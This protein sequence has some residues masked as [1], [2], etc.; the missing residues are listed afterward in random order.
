[1]IA[2]F[3]EATTKDPF[4]ALAWA[5]LAFCC[6]SMSE[7]D[8]DKNRADAI[9]ASEKAMQFRPQTGEALWAEAYVQDRL[10]RNYEKANFAYH[11]AKDRLPGEPEIRM[12]LAYLARRAGKWEDSLNYFQEAMVCY[13]WN[14]G[15]FKQW[16]E[17]NQAMH[18]F[19]VALE[20]Y[21]R[22]LKAAEYIDI[23]ALEISIY[24]AQ[25][26]FAKSGDLLRRL[27]LNPSEP[28]T[29]ESHFQQL[30]LRR[31]FAEAKKL[32]EQ[33]MAGSS[34]GSF[35]YTKY[36]IQHG[37]LEDALDGFP[38]DDYEQARDELKILR[39]KSPKDAEY[40]LFLS[41]AYLGLRRSDQAQAEAT[42]AVHLAGRS[43][44]AYVVLRMN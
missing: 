39:Q 11:Q 44:S 2:A 12:H 22:L 28:I 19:D 20:A 8:D 13:L 10:L 1:M 21:E 36:R 4:F 24:Q 26:D 14:S 6:V 41:Q 31:Q 35:Q 15:A 27:E 42:E 34:L 32:I 38:R 9:A 17:T 43:P 18:R 5:E 16:G 7:T 29:V 23:L 33:A 25:G 3:R 40:A 30:W 37:R